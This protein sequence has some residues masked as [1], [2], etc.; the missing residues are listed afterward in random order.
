MGNS[1]AWCRGQQVCLTGTFALGTIMGA[2]FE[3]ITGLPSV[4]SLITE[5]S[6][7]PG[8]AYGGHP[9]SVDITQWHRKVCV[10]FGRWLGVGSVV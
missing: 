3:D 4:G 6:S 10:L 7:V 9:D 8:L 2:P 5:T 1:S